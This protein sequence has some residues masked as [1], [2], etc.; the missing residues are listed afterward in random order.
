MARGTP[1]IVLTD[2]ERRELERMAAVP[3]RLEALRASIV[4]RRADGASQAAIAKELATTVPT[5]SKWCGGFAEKRLEALNPGK[6]NGAAAAPVRP[7]AREKSSPRQ[8][9]RTRNSESLESA[10]SPH[11]LREA[12]PRKI[13][14][15][16]PQQPHYYGHRERLRERFRTGGADALPDYE[17]MELLLFR[18]IPRRDTKPLAKQII[19]TFGSFAEAVS[20]PEERLAEVPGLGRAAACEIKV[21]QA[22]ALRMMRGN[23]MKRELLATWQQVLEYCRAAM[24]YEPREQ[25]RILFLD[26]RNRLIADE[27]QQRGTVN[28]TPVY[29]REV[30]HRALV[31]SATAIVLV[32]NHPS[33]DPSPS[34][35]DIELTKEIAK[36]AKG[37]SV[38]VH[39]HF[40]IGKDGYAS[41]KAQGYF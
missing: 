35:A 15:P 7:P 17:L 16:A 26:H 38:M 25:F 41:L 21:V 34:R 4:L 11:G 33:G 37:V 5:V 3:D 19:G 13:Q 39:D 2:A 8:C 18:A 28:H 32:H 31:L 24:A 30:I 6:R 36:A 27:V 14:V 23:V 40:I 1:P 10:A 29:V 20:A 12:P 22:A 9:S